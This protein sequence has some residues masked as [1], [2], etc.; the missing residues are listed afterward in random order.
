MSHLDPSLLAAAQR[1]KRRSTSAAAHAQPLATKPLLLKIVVLGSSNVGKTSLMRRYV[2]NAFEQHRRATIGAD[3][4]TK[5]LTLRN[6][7]VLL[8]IWD[9]AGQERF[10]QGECMCELLLC[11]FA[12]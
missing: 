6:T 9:T 3:F 11:E 4:M 2:A 1:D 7:A 12:N 5:E 8:Q 10:H